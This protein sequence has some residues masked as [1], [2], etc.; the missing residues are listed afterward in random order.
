MRVLVPISH[1]HSLPP[2]QTERSPIQ[3]RCLIQHGHWRTSFKG[4]P[5]L[6][7]GL[8]VSPF[9]GPALRHSGAASKAGRSPWRR[10][11][12]PR[13]LPGAVGPT[14]AARGKAPC[15]FLNLPNGENNGPYTAY[16]LSILACWAIILGSFGGSGSW[17]I[18]KGSNVVPLWVH[19]V[20]GPRG[21]ERTHQILTGG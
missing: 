3:P 8:P 6:A 1:M 7:P 20:F 2:K 10:A 5:P 19:G 13:G 11:G 17:Y 4:G 12:G 9:K 21:P 15:S 18:P 16:S 14:P